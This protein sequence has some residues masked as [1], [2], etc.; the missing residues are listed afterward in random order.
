MILYKLTVKIPKNI[1][2]I[3]NFKTTFTLLIARNLSSIY[4][5]QIIRLLKDTQSDTVLINKIVKSSYYKRKYLI[6]NL[7]NYYRTKD[8]FKELLVINKQN[9]KT[10]FLYLSIFFNSKPNQKMFAKLQED[11]TRAFSKSI[12]SFEKI[13]NK[14]EESRIRTR[15]DPKIVRFTI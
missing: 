13:S 5:L 2:A 3:K 4:D 1:R 11:L 6:K 8:T 9:R 15:V 10:N 7:N 12:L 14:L